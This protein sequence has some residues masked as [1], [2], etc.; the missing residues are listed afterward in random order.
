[1]TFSARRRIKKP[2]RRQIV[3][4]WNAVILTATTRKRRQTFIEKPTLEF[5]RTFASV[6]ALVPSE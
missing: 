5:F 3:G 4:K 6:F 2:E 1:L